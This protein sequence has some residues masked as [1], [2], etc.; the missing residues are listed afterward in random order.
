MRRL[1]NV[2]NADFIFAISEST[3]QDVMKYLDVPADKV[4]NVS[5]GVSSFFILFQKA[6]A[7]IGCKNSQKNLALR[8]I[9]FFTLVEKIGEKILKDF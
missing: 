3:R 1:K 4:L 6:I 8:E 9:F 7:K 2:K 5:G